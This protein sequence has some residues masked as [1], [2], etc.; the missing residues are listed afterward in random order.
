MSHRSSTIDH[1][2][3]ISV[4][5]VNYNAGKLLA[6]AVKS[7]SNFPGAE[8]IVIDNSPPNPNLGFGKAVNLGVKKSHGEYV[9][10]LNPDASLSKNALARMVETAKAYGNR[11]IIAP[12]LENQDGTPQSSCYRP[13]TLWNAVKE[14]WFNVKGAYSKYLPA[15]KAGLPVAVHAAVAA[16]GLVP[17]LV[18]D[19]LGGLSDRFFLYFEDIDMC[20]RAG[21]A[22]IPVI[23]DPRAVVKHAH[24]VSSRT[25]PIVLKLFTDSAWQYHG[26][27]KK[28]LI[29]LIIHARDLFVPPVSTKKIVGIL[30]LYTLL[31]LAIASLGY[32]LLPSRFAPS[33]LVPS[34]YHSNFLLWSWANFDGAHYL[35]IAQNG[36][37]TILG[38]S[39]YAFFPLLPLLINAVSRTGLDLYLSAHLITTFSAIGFIWILLKW[40]TKYVKNPLTLLWLVLLSPG[41]IFLSAIY[42][43]PL[44]LFLTVTTF[45]FSDRKQ[46][47]KAIF[48]AA[49]AT[50][51]RINGIF[52]VLFLLLKSRSLRALLGLSGILAYIYYLW[53]RTG[54]GL[55]FFHAQSGWGKSTLTLPWVTLTS[56]FRALTYEFQPDL[57]HLVVAIEVIVTVLLIYLLFRFWKAKKFHS[58][59][60]YYA[61]ATLALPLST[62][63]LGSMPRFSLALFPLFLMIPS[64]PRY[65]R[66]IHY[67]LFIILSIIGIIL[68]TRGYWYA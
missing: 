60:K 53:G 33:S 48:M 13:Q 63:S 4:I 67:S 55:A 66:I 18:W 40:A 24:G 43:E 31:V 25:N 51:T 50:A 16:A 21:K 10:L 14:Y 11:A 68:F 58:A 56:Y 45:Y 59:Y 17:R 19:E 28:I 41:A 52:L 44:F 22:G 1:R 27:F 20:D 37:Q 46:W 49:L 65:P 32:F 9:Y 42:S 26:K 29:D 12:R 5:I 64:L 47:G 34:L 62:G 8:V 54:D 35:N 39:E 3:L 57:T 61:L 15:G 7:I 2:P 38:Q 23:Y 6:Q 30:T 36:Y